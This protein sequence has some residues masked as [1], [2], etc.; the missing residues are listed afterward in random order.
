MSIAKII[1]I[2]PHRIYVSLKREQ[3]KQALLLTSVIHDLTES[4][5]KKT[6]LH[7]TAAN[8]IVTSTLQQVYKILEKAE[9][10]ASRF[11][12]KHVGFQYSQKQLLSALHEQG[13]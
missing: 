1:V 5:L 4:L 13:L 10:T 2:Q 8:I 3:V 6:W 7:Y 9:Q 11:W 12:A